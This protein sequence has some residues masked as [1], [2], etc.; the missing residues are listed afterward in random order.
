MRRGG[1]LI[2]AATLAI[3]I[4]APGNVSMS[5]VTSHDDNDH[6]GPASD[7]TLGDDTLIEGVDAWAVAG[8]GPT[9]FDPD[10]T[11]TS[12]AEVRTSTFV[13]TSI[14]VY[15]GVASVAPGQPLPVRVSTT[16]A[17]YSLSIARVTKGGLKT[18]YRSASLR[19]RDYRSRITFD[20]K[21]NMARAHWPVACFVGTSRFE[22]GVYIVS[23]TTLGGTVGRTVVVIRTP[24]LLH[25]DP[26]YVFP[27]LTYQAY[28]NWGGGS[29]YSR[30]RGYAV[31]FDRPYYWGGLSVWSLGDDR[32]IPWLMATVPHL[33][34][35]TDYDLST[36]PPSIAP[37]LVIFGRH[38]EYVG[39]RMRDWLDQHVLARG[40]MGI[41]NLGANGLYWQVRLTAGLDGAITETCY[42][43]RLLDPLVPVDP[44]LVTVR[45]RDVP[46]GRPEGL[47]LGGQY[48]G[49][50]R[51]GRQLT[52][53][54]TVT[55]V[56][57]GNLIA[58]TGWRIGTVLHGLIQ[59]ETDAQFGGA[60]RTRVVMTGSTVDPLGEHAVSGDDAPYDACR[61]SHLQWR[62]VQC[63]CRNRR[64]G[65]DGCVVG[66]I[67]AVPV[68][69]DRVGRERRRR[70]RPVT[71]NMTPRRWDR[72]GSRSLLGG[73]GTAPPSRAWSPARAAASASP[74]SPGHAR[75]P[76]PAVGHG[77][78]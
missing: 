37:S 65:A 46:V 24:I 60:R 58:G 32:L 52:A 27:A 57:P 6:A 74:G 34:F 48:A 13:R 9:A 53:S 3:M 76:D 71:W 7:Y 66:F 47:L 11:V 8:G 72:A 26:A 25:S 78:R 15:T 38:T 14:E 56:M 70:R 75:R 2:I 50:V 12:T 19:G 77:P 41:V 20:P 45:W 23:A 28:N 51:D 62:D 29:L 44:A 67:A 64:I 18:V 73:C 22:P 10:A 61:C 31:S 1:F 35:T 36:A 49:V 5:G 54:F 21:T 33:Q 42:K 30:P 63:R 17:E 59:G 4:A 55:S 43:S 69:R 39:V 40:D 68:Q 16:A